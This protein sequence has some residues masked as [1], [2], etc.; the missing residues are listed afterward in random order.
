MSFE[1][2]AI[3]GLGLLGLAHWLHVSCAASRRPDS[4]EAAPG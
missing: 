1:R 3:I 4:A 2:V